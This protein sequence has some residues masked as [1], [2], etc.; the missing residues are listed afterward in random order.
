MTQLIAALIYLGLLLMPGWLLARLLFPEQH[1]FLFSYSLSLILLSTCLLIASSVG[2]HPL[3]WLNLIAGVIVIL[4]GINV[5]QELQKRTSRSERQTTLMTQGS[6]CHALSIL[7]I[8]FSFS[9]YHLTVGPYSEIPSDIWIHLARVNNVFLNF[10]S[11][12]SNVCRPVQCVSDQGHLIYLLH[13]SVA[14]LVRVDPINLITISTLVTGGLFLSSVYF[15]SVSVF[16]DRGI[17]IRLCALGGVLAALLTLILFGTASFSFVRYYSYFPVVFAFPVFFLATLLFIGYLESRPSSTLVCWLS[18]PIFILLMQTIHRQEAF[19]FLL[20]SAVLALVYGAET[21]SSKRFFLPSSSYR[22]RR[23]FFYFTIVGIVITTYL[24]FSLEPNEWKGTPHVVDAGLYLA[25]LTG[26]P[27]DNPSFRLWDT[28]G[29][30]GL[31][32]LIWAIFRWRLVVQSKFLFVSLLIPVL[33]NLNPFYAAL[34]LRL[35]MPSTLWRTAYLFPVG[36][37]AAFL[38]VSC[39]F[40]SADGRSR[41]PDYLLLIFLVAACVPWQVGEFYNR[42]SRIP[43]LYP[44]AAASGA[45]LWGDLIDASLAL[46]SQ[47]PIK[48]I[49]TDSTTRFI[50]EASTRG[51]V[52]SRSQGFY[53]P[54]HNQDYQRDFLE[55]DYS[56]SLLV[57]NRRDGKVTA[58]ARYSGHWPANTLQVSQKYPPDL[59]SFIEKHPNLF[60]RLWSSRDIDIFLMKRDVN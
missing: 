9:F 16:C 18:V 20:I 44:S 22:R 31:V 47:I 38:V 36:I 46:Q 29:Y 3:D 40:R 60:E 23:S 8:I 57:I 58:N 26:L 21:F 14:T 12:A 10:D 7:L 15:F 39:I 54:K 56:G 49:I 4:I 43:S 48:R 25:W 34:F 27:L 17:S 6:K 24:I 41:I 55:S 45:Q 30:S 51:T 13:A 32:V 1:R 52:Q 37:L 53:F 19:F 33:T 42:T 50:L 11:I 28:I 5:Y 59:D 2:Y 35:D